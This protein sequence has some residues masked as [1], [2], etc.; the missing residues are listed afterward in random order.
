MPL[1]ASACLRTVLELSWLAPGLPPG[2]IWLASWAASSPQ[3]VGNITK[4]IDFGLRSLCLPLLASACLRMAPGLPP[5]R[6]LPASR[7]PLPCFLGS[8]KPQTYKCKATESKR[9]ERGRRCTP[10]A[11]S[12]R[13]AD[14]GNKRRFKQ[15]RALCCA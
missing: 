12:I 13:R 1:L 10:Q 9:Q 6:P 4:T 8:L 14:L 11:S 7:L 15:C 2:S 3:T 5:A